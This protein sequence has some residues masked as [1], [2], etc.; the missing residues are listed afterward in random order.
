MNTKAIYIQNVAN[1]LPIKTE[2]K[3]IRRHTQKT[4]ALTI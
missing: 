2:E 1:R 3:E 4:S